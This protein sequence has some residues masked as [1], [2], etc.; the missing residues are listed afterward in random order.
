MITKLIDMSNKYPED[1]IRIYEISKDNEQN[2]WYE[3]QEFAEHGTLKKFN[4][5]KP[6]IC[7]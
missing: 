3:I 4:R 7:Y 6:S 1:I 2:R 5:R